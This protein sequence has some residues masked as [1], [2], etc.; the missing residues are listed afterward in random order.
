V[1]DQ[2]EQRSI[3]PSTLKFELCS[4]QN[5]YVLLCHHISLPYKMDRPANVL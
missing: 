2:E 4:T 5:I 1:F 3:L